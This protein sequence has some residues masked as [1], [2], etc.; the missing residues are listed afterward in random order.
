MIPLFIYLIYEFLFD[1]AEKLKQCHY[2]KPTKPYY[3]Y[4]AGKFNSKT[5]DTIIVSKIPYLIHI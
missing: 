2:R 5:I 1:E 4:R 3:F